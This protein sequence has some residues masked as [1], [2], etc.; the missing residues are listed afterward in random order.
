MARRTIG[1]DAF[2]FVA[3][4]N[5]SDLDDLSKLV[6]WRAAD[7]LM[8]PISVAAK[9]EPGWPP[10]CLLQALALGALVRPE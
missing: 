8:A 4:G 1:Q 9:G 5:K 6:D 10:L 7:V 2:S 3:A